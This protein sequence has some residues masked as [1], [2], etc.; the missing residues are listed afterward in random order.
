MVA[1]AAGEKLLIGRRPYQ[2]LNPAT[3]FFFVSL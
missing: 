3:I 2:E 1:I